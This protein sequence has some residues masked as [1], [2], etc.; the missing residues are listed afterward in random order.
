MDDAVFTFGL[1]MCR[2]IIL[3]FCRSVGLLGWS[4]ESVIVSS[5]CPKAAV[6]YSVENISTSSRWRLMVCVLSSVVV[7]FIVGMLVSL[8][9]MSLL[10]S[11][12]LICVWLSLEKC[13]N[14]WIIMSL[15]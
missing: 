6:G 10:A 8:A 4:T 5:F 7:G 1:P 9:A 12:K 2:Q 11:L 13:S 15:K 3:V 14:S